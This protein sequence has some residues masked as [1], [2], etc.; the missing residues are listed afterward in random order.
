[1]PGA[2]RV[3]VTIDSVSTARRSV[4]RVDLRRIEYDA[5]RSR[6]SFFD[7]TSK[8][9]L[10]ATVAP[11][12]AETIARDLGLV[13]E[14]RCKGTDGYRLPG[15][16]LAIAV[17]G[18]ALAVF[19]LR[20]WLGPV[21]PVMPVLPI[22]MFGVVMSAFRLRAG[23]HGVTETRLWSPRHHPYGTI[24]RVDATKDSVI[25]LFRNGT[26][27][28]FAVGGLMEPSLRRVVAESFAGRVRAGIARHLTS[29]SRA[30]VRLALQ[31]GG[32]APTEWLDRLRALRSDD[33][34]SGRPA[35]DELWRI[36]EDPAE[37]EASRGAAAFILAPGEKDRARVR[38]AIDPNVSGALREA[39]EAFADDENERAETATGSLALRRPQRS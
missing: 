33:Y 11:H 25:L 35:S 31:P 29:A 32:L 7:G 18:M 12:E 21:L 3:T 13:L 10:G 23:V 17:A 14:E 36:L 27:T 20:A 9:R 30:E 1:M 4:R 39:L 28:A 2:K 38:V 26:T 5:A 24:E 22:V 6:L 15:L 37:D 34:R 8:E 19:L 16:V